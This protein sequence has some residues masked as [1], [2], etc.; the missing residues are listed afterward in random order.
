MLY[1]TF[2]ALICI[3]K[4]LPFDHLHPFPPPPTPPLVTTNPISFSMSF[5]ICLFLKFN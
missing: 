3:W 5:F 1:M 4:F 2:L